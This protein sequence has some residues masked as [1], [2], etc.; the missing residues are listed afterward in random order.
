MI[1]NMG[2][3]VYYYRSQAQIHTLG[4]DL[5]STQFSFFH[6]KQNIQ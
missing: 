1:E 6:K 4:T 3:K 2:I 5:K